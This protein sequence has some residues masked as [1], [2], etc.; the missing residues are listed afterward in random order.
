MAD[1]DKAKPDDILDAYVDRLLAVED[2]GNHALDD[3]DLR[4]V[5]RELGLTEEQLAKLDQVVDDHLTRGRNFLDRGLFTDAAGEIHQAAVLRPFDAVIA[6][7]LARAHFGQF[8]KTRDRR[9]RERAQRFARRAVDIDPEHAPAY[10]LLQACQK[11]ERPATNRLLPMLGAVA[12]LGG[13]GALLWTG[14]GGSDG[15]EETS[16]PVVSKA[17]ENESSGGSATSS[18]SIAPE[19]DIP[20]Q[21]TGDEIDGLT[22]NVE[23][24]RL[25]R[26]TSASF[27]YTFDGTLTVAGDEL[28]LLHVRLELLSPSGEVLRQKVHKVYEDYRPRLRPGESTRVHLLFFEKSDA[29]DVQSARLVV[30]LRDSMPAATDYGQEP[31]VELLWPGTRPAYI[32]LVVRERK[33]EVKALFDKRSHWL[34]LSFTNRGTRAVEKLT[35]EVVALAED[36]SELARK[37]SL[38]V[39]GVGP[40]LPAGQTWVKRLISELDVGQGSSARSLARYQI[41]VLEAE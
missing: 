6:T 22:L 37:K 7:D 36:G 15:P 13:G 24:S 12:L 28:R 8:Q 40:A 21:L 4:K 19:I 38:V 5:A 32:D 34:T 25:R 41:R 30:E 29:P 10:E 20:L 14:L 27:A 23:R 39:P 3:S 2:D 35:L 16:A 9:E 11:P 26:Y 17:P 31:E 18:P 1:D 33:S